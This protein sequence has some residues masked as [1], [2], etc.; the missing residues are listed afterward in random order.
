MPRMGRGIQCRRATGLSIVVPVYNSEKTLEKLVSRL[1]PVLS[2]A[3]AN[4]EVILVDD[5]SPDD[6]W[7]VIQRL[8]RAFPWVHG[9]NLMLI[10][11]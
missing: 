7:S 11:E 8:S 3:A 5:G 4:Y 9:V 6:S 1:Q 2:Q 10:G